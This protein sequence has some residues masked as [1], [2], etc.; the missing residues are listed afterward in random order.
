MNKT[1]LKQWKEYSEW[2]DGENKKR[3]RRVKRLQKK[4]DQQHEIYNKEQK[5]DLATLLWS[6]SEPPQCIG[7]PGRKRGNPAWVIWRG[8]E[9]LTLSF[10]RCSQTFKPQLVIKSQE[11]FM[12]Y[13]TKQI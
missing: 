10:H 11:G 9:A 4:E 7:P 13:L 1:E 2:V 12:D 5:E 6:E 3:V 8:S